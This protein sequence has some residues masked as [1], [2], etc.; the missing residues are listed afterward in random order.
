MGSSFFLDSPEPSLRRL[1]AGVGTVTYSSPEQ[2]HGTA[3]DLKV[4]KTPYSRVSLDWLIDWFRLYFFAVGYVQ[5]RNRHGWATLSLHHRNGT[6][7]LVDQSA[8]GETLPPGLAPIPGPCAGDPAVTADRPQRAASCPG[9]FILRHIYQQRSG[10]AQSPFSSTLILRIH[11]IFISYHFHSQII[12]PWTNFFH[13]QI[14]QAL[15]QQLAQ[16]QTEL[17]TLQALL[18]ERTFPGAS[19]WVPL[20]GPK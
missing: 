11:S 3:Y 5:S 17:I 1:S 15:S 6:S 14:I 18:A 4:S 2:L 8:C 13:S 10:M 12:T 9:N 16:Q 19:E 20:V 7:H